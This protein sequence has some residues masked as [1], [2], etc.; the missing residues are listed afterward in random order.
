MS[1]ILVTGVSGF[2]ALH[3]IDQLLAQQYTRHSAVA[4]SRKDE[5]KAALG[6]LGH[7]TGNFTLS[8]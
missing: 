3:C 2:I 6:R 4:F 7:D 5:I 1:K 8:G